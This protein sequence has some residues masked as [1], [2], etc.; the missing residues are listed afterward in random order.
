M[1][2]TQTL[3]FLD[4]LCAKSHSAYPEG[5]VLWTYVEEANQAHTRL[6]DPRRGPSVGTLKLGKLETWFQV[7]LEDWARSESNA[8]AV[9]ASNELL[10]LLRADTG[11]DQFLGLFSDEGDAMTANIYSR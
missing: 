3:Q 6:S 4:D 8:Y 11:A 10:R 9:Q 1:L 2:S 5:G 7:A